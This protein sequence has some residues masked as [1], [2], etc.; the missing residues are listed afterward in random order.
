M[1]TEIC[2]IK[3]SVDLIASEFSVIS[4]RVFLEVGDA[5]SGSAEVRVTF[6]PT[7]PAWSK[8]IHPLECFGSCQEPSH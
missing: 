1:L 8:C 6:L 5:K 4:Y 2:S 7:D 3:P